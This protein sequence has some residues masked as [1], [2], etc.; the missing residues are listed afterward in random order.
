MNSLYQ[1]QKEL[2]YRIKVNSVIFII[3]KL[4]KD[5]PKDGFIATGF[6]VFYKDNYYIFSCGHVLKE[7]EKDERITVF[8]DFSEN[9]KITKDNIDRIYFDSENLDIGY[10]K[11]KK[12]FI[13]KGLNFIS[14]LQE[15]FYLDEIEWD[16]YFIFIYGYPGKFARITNNKKEYEITALSLGCTFKGVHKNNIYWMF[17]YPEGDNV[18][19]DSEYKIPKPFGLS[20]CAIW[21]LKGN[22]K[23]INDYTTAKVIAIGH[24]WNRTKNLFIAT[25]IKYLFDNIDRSENLK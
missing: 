14:L 12:D 16:N 1:R 19:T 15:D 17:D 22:N 18:I 11:I 4:Y 7:F 13:V 23:F 6:W 10:I 21:A 24:S 2:E 5:N 9:I 20:G 3:E 25:P 8:S